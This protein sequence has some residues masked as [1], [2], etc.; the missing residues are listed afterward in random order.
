MVNKKKS[1]NDTVK[2]TGREKLPK[3]DRIFPENLIY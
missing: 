3:N 1:I 2:K